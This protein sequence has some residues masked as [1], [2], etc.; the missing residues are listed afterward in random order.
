M[1]FLN[2]KSVKITILALL[3][4]ILLS[5]PFLIKGLGF[6]AL[7]S[8]VPIF[9][10]DTYLREHKIKRPWWIIFCIF[11][12]WNLVTTYWIKNATLAGAIVAIIANAFQMSLIY[13]LFRLF[14]KKMEEVRGASKS[15]LLPY[16]FFIMTWLT[17]EHIYFNVQISW[18]WLTLGN[19]FAGSIKMIQWY[20]ITGTLGGSFW[21]LLTSVAT[22]RII[23]FRDQLRMQ[24][25]IAF[26]L[27]IFGP[28]IYSSIKYKH[29]KEIQDPREVVALQPN[30]DPYHDKFIGMSR[31]EQDAL[32]LA[33]CENTVTDSTLFVVS[34]ETFTSHINEDHPLSFITSRRVENFVKR[35]KNVNFLLGAISVKFYPWNKYKDSTEEHSPTLTA[36]KMQGYWYDTYNSAFLFNDLSE[37]SHVQRYHKSKLVVLA[38]FVPYP[39]LLK[40]LN[41]LAIKLGGT[42]GS[43]AT[44]KEVSVME[45]N[46]GTKIGTAIC[47]ESVYG[48][49]Y[50]QYVNKG[51]QIMAIMTNDGWWGNT[52]GYHQHFRYASLRAI[53]TRRSIIRS[54]NTGISA[55][56]NQR[57]DVIMRTKW[58]KKDVLRGNLNLNNK[59]TIYVENGDIIGRAAAFIFALFSL[60]LL[61]QFFYKK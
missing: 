34:P 22:Y 38:E 21:I 9:Y 36:K 10:L 23:K 44:Q 50:R 28:L 41:K 56:I 15:S 2:K 49:Y 40:P 57:G 60:L 37:E 32:L 1:S 11:F 61:S 48:D 14:R 59:M 33:Q 52:P 4:V 58:W 16:V 47:Y 45:A 19:A 17:W 54:A 29:Y 3:A 46:D 24:G 20:D 27:L 26:L 18:P 39:K 55:L 53:E 30:I 6:I 51:A 42:T 12:T 25:L 8:F 13:A 7:F 5:L 43:Y 35:H 31:E